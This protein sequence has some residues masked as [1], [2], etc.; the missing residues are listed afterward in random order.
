MSSSVFSPVA[1]RPCRRALPFVLASLLGVACGR[2]VA[3]GG[4]ENVAVVVNA[5]SW[6]SLAVANEYVNLRK[7]PEGNVVYLT[8]LPSNLSIDVNQFRELI[9]T[10]VLKAL[11]QRGL[12]GQIDCVAY[13]AD[14]PCSVNVRPD[15]GTSPAHRVLTPEA[16]VNGLTYLY[17]LVLAK[18]PA[19][20]TLDVNRY[21]RQR[22]GG[23]GEPAW[24]PELREKLGRA[25][26]LMHDKKW[27][28]AEPALRE[29]VAALPNFALV[30][31][32]L[33]CCLARQDKPDDAMA[34]FHKAVAAGWLDVRH[35]QR[36]EDLASLRQRP[37]F[38]RLLAQ[39]EATPFETQPP[40]AFY[41]AIGWLPNGEP[42]AKPPDGMRYLLSTMLAVTSG[43]GNS[44][45]EA[46]AGLRRS[47]AADGIRPPGTV[48]YVQNSDI[49]STT[50]QWGFASAVRQLAALGV[51]AEVVQG[52]LPDKKADVAGVM[53]GAADFRW[54]A[55]GSTILPGAICEHLTS[56]GGIMH[57]AGGQ[58]PLSELLRYGAAAASGT[59][60][61]PYAIQ[62]KFPTAFLHVYYASGCT[63]AEAFYQSV[64]GPYQLLIVGDPLCRP[65]ARIPQVSIDGLAPGAV[66]K[67]QFAIR[68]KISGAMKIARYELYLD[69]RRA[70]VT[71]P[72]AELRLPS[73]DLSDGYHEL[74]LVVV[75]ADLAETRGH[76]SL[77]FVVDNRGLS[78][79]VEP[80]PKTV[81]LDQTLTL[82]AKMPGAKRIV[83]VHDG[84]ELG[85]IAAAEGAVTVPATKLGL[86][87]V[88]VRAVAFLGDAVQPTPPKPSAP[89]A[90][91]A[92][93]K[94]KP[95]I[96]EG[97]P[98]APETKP[99]AAEAKP[100][101]EKGPKPADFY[102]G[103]PIELE[104]LPPQPLAALR[105]TPKDL[106]P[107]LKLTPAGADSV[108]VERTR[109]RDWL[110]KAVPAGKEFVLEGFFEVP[111]QDV[112]QFQLRGSTPV[113]V[114]VD[115]R[116]LS[117]SVVNTGAVTYLPVALAAGTHKLTVK[118]RAGSQATLEIGFGGPGTP[119]AG[120]DRFRH[121]KF[122]PPK[123]TAG[124]G[125]S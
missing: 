102:L 76:A 3:S 52:V 24:T 61:E 1:T 51:R 19:Y 74:R 121:P 27:S 12:A 2:A 63:L 6:A 64:R 47:A 117:C 99:A 28:E 92:A 32:D 96:P 107:G 18:N 88:R 7:V 82:R 104:I 123:A 44:V 50:R 120:A 15:V 89:E 5:D 68:P 94:A 86:G 55:S 48:Y 53:I 90:K 111:D 39:I 105:E 67:G 77:P 91:P 13:S 49:R 23:P 21:F 73:A 87:K 26:Q 79:H 46:I 109:D 11:E 43:R 98:A 103:A 14:V 84:R 25:S 115:E 42:A 69:G 35:A 106:V 101:A 9:L 10:P 66:V 124:S 114:A 29:L 31:Y 97:K 112:Y 33:A 57:E 70:A 108:V 59:V 17:G 45:R 93:S 71:P 22:R 113:E 30:H 110:A 122:A 81:T 125:K 80:L 100:E 40:R 116:V 38:K 118:G 60:T 36:D 95:A 65:W 119:S 72:V 34:A 58:T 37:E 85:T 54:K 41:N 83:F 75:T 16:A 78:L 56:C 62:N 8:G 20:L 4:P